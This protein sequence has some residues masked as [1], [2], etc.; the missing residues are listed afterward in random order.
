MKKRNANMKVKIYEQQKEI[1]NITLELNKDSTYEKMR[2][3]LKN[4]TQFEPISLSDV[5][6]YTPKNKEVRQ[7]L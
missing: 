4:S 7:A 1:Q 2:I 3:F 6:F 5:T